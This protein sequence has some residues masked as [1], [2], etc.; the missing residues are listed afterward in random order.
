MLPLKGVIPLAAQG[1]GWAEMQGYTCTVGTTTASRTTPRWPLLLPGWDSYQRGL[2]IRYS[3]SSLDPTVPKELLK[4]YRPLFVPPSSGNFIPSHVSIRW[5]LYSFPF[6]NTSGW[7]RASRGVGGG[8]GAENVA[9]R[10][11]KKD[12][13][14]P[15]HCPPSPWDAGGC[16]ETWVAAGTRR[17][18]RNW[19]PRYGSCKGDVVPPHNFF[20]PL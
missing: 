2:G 14:L 19:W 3:W 10:Q 4:E 1:E 13:L 8:W 20:L 12:V 7:G 18:V 5:F 15:L 16:T 9:P 17:T 6:L 11:E